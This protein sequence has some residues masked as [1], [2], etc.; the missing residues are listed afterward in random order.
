MKKERKSATILKPEIDEQAALQFASAGSEPVPAP[1]KDK[2]KKAASKKRI[3]QKDSP[4]DIPK[5]MRQISLIIKKDLYDRIAKDAAR[6]NRT[7]E[8]HLK[9]HLTKRYHK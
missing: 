5:D 8:E 3:P 7:V 2:P 4:A 6:K 1:S 9:K